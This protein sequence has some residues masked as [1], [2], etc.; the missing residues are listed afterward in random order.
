MKYYT[1]THHNLKQWYFLKDKCYVYNT[2]TTNY[3]WLVVIRYNLNSILKLLFNSPITINN[4]L[5][6]KI[7]YKSIVKML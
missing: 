6:L 2:F 1:E 4:D 5:P 7:Y 3:R